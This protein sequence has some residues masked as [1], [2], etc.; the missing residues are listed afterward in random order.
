MRE[1][2]QILTLWDMEPSTI[3]WSSLLFLEPAPRAWRIGWR[4]TP[5]VAGSRDSPHA[6]APAMDI[7]TCYERCG[8]EC[9]SPSLMQDMYGPSRTPLHELDSIASHGAIEGLRITSVN[10]AS[11]TASTLRV[12][13]GWLWMI[14]SMGSQTAPAPRVNSGRRLG[15][16][17][18]RSSWSPA[19]VMASALDAAGHAVGTWT[20]RSTIHP[21]ST[22]H[23]SWQGCCAW[24]RQH[25]RAQM[26]SHSREDHG[27]AS[28]KLA[29]QACNRWRHRVMQQLHHTHL[30]WAA[31]AAGWRP[32]CVLLLRV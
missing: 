18:G 8:A 3:C 5:L 7:R 4:R 28:H 27:P 21:V 10:I 17:P 32:L 9:S 1:G 14:E 19:G 15:A 12:C 24:A 16:P 31:D 2:Y 30:Q 29:D 26:L 6:A 25:R 11:S 23:W 20:P 13:V 22:P